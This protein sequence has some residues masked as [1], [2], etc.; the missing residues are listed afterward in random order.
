MGSLSNH[1]GG[2]SKNVTNF[3]LFGNVKRRLRCGFHWLTR[4][5]F[6]SFRQTSQVTSRGCFVHISK[7]RC[8]RNRLGYIV[9]LMRPNG[10]GSLAFT[11][12]SRVYQLLDAKGNRRWSDSGQW[13]GQAGQLDGKVKRYNF[14][15]KF[16]SSLHPCSKHSGISIVTRFPLS[17]RLQF[18]L[19]PT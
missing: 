5:E 11:L 1:D 4:W 8:Y 18:C 3:S 10:S 9:N 13:I 7:L 15:G 14:F 6:N 2:G 19:F 12:L 17:V 16:V